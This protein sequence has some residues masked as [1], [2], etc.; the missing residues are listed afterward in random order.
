MQC[1]KCHY[2]ET[3]VYDTRSSN[4]GKNIRRRRKCMECKYRFTTLEVVKVLDLKVEKRNGQV[5]DFDETR[6]EFGVRKAFNKRN[7]DNQKISDLVQKVVD[8]ILTT[9]KNP[10][11]TTRIGKIVLKNLKT[12]DEAAYICFGAMFWSFESTDDFNKLLDDFQKD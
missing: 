5:V 4:N 11:K 9:G 6:L 12:T 10:I 3:K 8:D 2:P 1:P 7:I